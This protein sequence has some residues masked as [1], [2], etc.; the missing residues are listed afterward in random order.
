MSA[1][2]REVGDTCGYAPNR[3]NRERIITE[4]FSTMNHKIT[5]ISACIY[6]YVRLT[7][8]WHPF[9]RGV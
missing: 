5:M 4:D 2:E 6:L 3:E 7:S 1:R 8:I 9:G